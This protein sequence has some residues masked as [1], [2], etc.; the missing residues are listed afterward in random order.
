TVY[1]VFG[2]VTANGERTQLNLTGASANYADVVKWELLYGNFLSDSDIDNNGRVAVLG[3]DVV[4]DLWGN[5]LFNPVG[6]SIRISDRSF[7]VIWVMTESGGTFISEDNVVFIPITTAQTRL[8]DARTRDGG[9][10]VSTIQV[11]VISEEALESARA[12]ITA[13]LDVAH[14]VVL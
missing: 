11:E 3:M 5:R 7:T 12:Q 10:R 6:Q 8:D 4:E 1:R 13:Y 9:Y 14:G 2:I